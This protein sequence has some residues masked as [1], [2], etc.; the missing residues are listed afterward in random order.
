MLKITPEQ[1]FTQ[2]PPRFTEASL[3]KSLEEK[4]IGRPSTYASIITVIKDREYIKTE[5]RKIHPSELG[6]LVSELL[7]EN[8]PDIMTDE[9]TANM[10]DRLDKIEE[11]EA[12]WV[13]TLKSFYDPFQKD[14]EKAEK[15]MRDVKGEVEQTDAVC[16]KCGKGMVIKW[17][18]FGK[19]M[20]CSGYPECK[21]T[22]EL[23]GKEGGTTGGAVN[24]QVEGKCEKCEAPLVMKIGRFGKFIA[25]SKYPECKFT[26]PLSLGV[27][28][29]TE[30]CKGY[31]SARRSKKGRAFYG[32]SEYPKCTFTSWDKPVPEVCPQCQAPYLVEKWKKNEGKYLMCVKEGCD[33]KATVAA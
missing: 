15:S 18:R 30:G 11:G 24:E 26:K 33:Y 25:C 1:H 27:S 23:G 19:F 9:F 20:A 17:G 2:P 21:T 6:I 5:E 12:E 10:E 28:C 31:V 13:G 4:G 29:P 22:R 7:V 32:C 14:L 3:I 16:E 8:F